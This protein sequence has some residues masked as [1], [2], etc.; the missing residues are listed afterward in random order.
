L[1]VLQKGELIKQLL[2]RM[3][4]LSIPGIDEH[5]FAIQCIAF[6]IG[7]TGLLQMPGYTLDLASYDENGVFIPTECIEG[8]CIT[9][10]FIEGRTVTVELRDFSMVEICSIL[11]GLFGS[12]AVFQEHF[13]D[14]EI[15]IINPEWMELGLIPLFHCLF[16]MTHLV[17]EI[18]TL[19]SG[20][21]LN[22][23]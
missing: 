23:T 3:F 21:I 22:N 12:G 5:G 15:P 1:V 14:T 20:K 18:H 7:G 10:T 11:E 19:F 13:I 4:M 8:I 9:F 2:G 17:E 6:C 16:Q